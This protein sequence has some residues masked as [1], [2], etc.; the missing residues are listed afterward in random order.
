M[1]VWCASLGFSDAPFQTERF[2]SACVGRIILDALP[3][4]MSRHA[5]E[6]KKV[7]DC[8]YICVSKRHLQRGEVGASAPAN[9]SQ[10]FRFRL[11][12]RPEAALFQVSSTSHFPP[13]NY[14]AI[15]KAKILRSTYPETIEQ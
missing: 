10:C 2:S 13:Q 14:S 5:Q 6:T 3:D 1:A 11:L 7:C 9:V 12:P 4:L 8:L 15:S